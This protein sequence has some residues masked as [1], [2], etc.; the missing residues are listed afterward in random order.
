M[1]R[2]TINAV[3]QRR[4]S[5]VKYSWRKLLF[6]MSPDRDSSHRS[7]PDRASNVKPS[8]TYLSEQKLQLCRQ[9]SQIAN[10][11]VAEYAT[12]DTYLSLLRNTRL[13]KNKQFVTLGPFVSRPVRVT[14]RLSASSYYSRLAVY[15]SRHRNGAR[16]CRRRNKLK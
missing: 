4:A 14:R 2:S 8:F 10:P 3:R 11:C 15:Y 9:G 13:G 5:I 1:I 12:R 16:S 7:L 6:A